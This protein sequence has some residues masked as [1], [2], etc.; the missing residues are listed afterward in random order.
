MLV[1]SSRRPVL[2]C[3]GDVG[4][5]A[6][7][8]AAKTEAKC[9]GSRAMGDKVEWRPLRQGPSVAKRPDGADVLPRKLR[10]TNVQLQA[11]LRIGVM[12]IL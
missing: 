9:H 10:E 12:D 11:F 8:G 1:S 4:E 2:L 7:C 6:L 3:A 5:G